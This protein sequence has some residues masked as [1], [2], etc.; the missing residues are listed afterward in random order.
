MNRIVS[1]LLPAVVR[2]LAREVAP[3]RDL[4]RHPCRVLFDSGSSMGLR[5][6]ISRK[7]RRAGEVS[8]HR[9]R[10]PVGPNGQAGRSRRGGSGSWRG[11]PAGSPPQ[12]AS[13]PRAAGILR[14]D[15]EAWWRGLWG[16]WLRGRGER[17]P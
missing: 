7:A 11:G 6:V 12:P 1:F 3:S 10:A 4:L 9:A 2:G 8:A 17:V 16:G 14:G 13:R 15:G 5:L